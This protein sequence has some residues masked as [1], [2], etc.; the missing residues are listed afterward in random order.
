MPWLDLLSEKELDL[1]R[2]L[3]GDIREHRVIE[4]LEHLSGERTDVVE[5]ELDLISRQN[6]HCF[7]AGNR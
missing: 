4:G 3:F 5:V 1:C 6:I 7:F 2:V